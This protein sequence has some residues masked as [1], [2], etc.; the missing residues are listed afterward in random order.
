[1]R[2]LMMPTATSS[3]VHLLHLIFMKKALYAGIPI[4]SLVWILPSMLVFL[5]YPTNQSLLTLIK[6]LII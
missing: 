2:S 5:T 6:A 1:M 3:K 4:I